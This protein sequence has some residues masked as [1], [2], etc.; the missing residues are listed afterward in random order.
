MNPVELR[1]YQ[2][3]AVKD[4]ERS[5][6]THINCIVQM[7]TGT[8]KTTVI[9][10]LIKR[11]LSKTQQTIL[12]IAH[13]AELIDQLIDRFQTFGI[14]CGRLQSGFKED[15][16]KQVQVGMIQSLRK[17]RRE[18]IEPYLVIIDEAHHIAADSYMNLVTYY[19]DIE[20]TYVGFT[21]T[22][23]RL[24]GK[25]LDKV[26]AKLFEYGSI[27][28]FIQNG[29]LS[30]M[31]HYASGKPKLDNI[32]IKR[33]GDYDIE[34]LASEMGENK[35][36]ADLIRG[37]ESKA[38]GKK[39]IVF[40]VNIQHAQDI[41]FRYSEKG[42]NSAV[43]DYNT[44]KV[45]RQSIIDDFKSGNIKI[46][47]NVNIFTEGF[48]C[49]DVEVIQLARPTK[50][51]NLY[52]QM[53]GRG[54]RVYEGKEKGIILDNAMLWEEHGRITRNHKWSIKGGRESDSYTYQTRFTEMMKNGPTPLDEDSNLELFKIPSIE[55][56]ATEFRL[57]SW[58]LLF[59][60]EIDVFMNRCIQN[61]GFDYNTLSLS[62][63]NIYNHPISNKAYSIR[64]ALKLFD[65]EF[66]NFQHEIHVR[67][68]LSGFERFMSKF[69]KTDWD[70][71]IAMNSFMN[72]V[73]RLYN[74]YSDMGLDAD[75]S[76]GSGS[77]LLDY[78]KKNCFERIGIQDDIAREIIEKLTFRQLEMMYTKL[79]S[80]YK[81]NTTP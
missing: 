2:I 37:Y 44:D 57:L 63:A 14:T 5:L 64:D 48:D 31:I 1:P 52:L 6:N 20:P 41:A 73:S 54:M 59:P 40:A 46:L 11:Q 43:V 9:A 78:Y 75:T 34:E 8:G 36:M 32:N 38:K 7:P 60:V 19:R 56:S 80:F 27:S 62:T 33:T 65:F 50:S 23:S 29:H 17:K 79:L 42:Y 55:E 81:K 76:F 53:V 15:L 35:N 77:I 24:D 58:A 51:L 16:E 49:P 3:E 28:E 39:M 22:P 74:E 4:V 30:P 71:A 10:E 68:I 13:R 25:P 69:S 67:N 18:L 70:E 12:V 26:F 47:C 61:G 66:D 21:A 72:K 45:E